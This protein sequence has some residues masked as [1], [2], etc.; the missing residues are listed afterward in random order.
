[1]SRYSDL[2]GKRFGHL[3]VVKRTNKKNLKNHSWHWLC[4]CDCGRHI[5]CRTDNLKSGHSTKCSDCRGNR[6]GAVSVFWDGVT[7]V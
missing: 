7:E 4:R 3:T 6:G 1:M 5:I 2:V